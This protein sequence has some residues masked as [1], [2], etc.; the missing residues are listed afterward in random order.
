MSNEQ[1]NNPDENP[2]TNQ[3]SIHDLNDID[4]Q[5]EYTRFIQRRA[6]I[7]PMES[8]HRINVLLVG[9]GGREHAYYSALKQSNKLG[10]VFCYTGQ[11]S[12]TDGMG[13]KNPGILATYINS[14][15]ELDNI[16]STIAFALVGP[17]KFL[18]DG[19]VDD[20][21]NI[22]IP[23]IG[24][25]KNL[26]QIETSKLFARKI[27]DKLRI[28]DT[29]KTD[30]DYKNNDFSGIFNPYYVVID[31][32]L[33]INSITLKIWE[34]LD[35]FGCR[36]LVVK[37]DG[38]ASGKGV[39]TSFSYNEELIEYVF[40][41]FKTRKCQRV[42][43]EEKLAGQ[44]FTLMS[45]CDG[46]KL[47]HTPVVFDYKVD[48]PF[49]PI[50]TGG[51]GSVLTN[52]LHFG[53]TEA[54]ISLAK[55]INQ[56]VID[57]M[58][59]NTAVNNERYIGILYGSFIKT[60]K[61]EIK[62]IEYNARGGDSEIIN[63]LD[64]METQF[65]DVCQSMVNGDICDIKFKIDEYLTNT[66]NNTYIQSKDYINIVKY[67]V[68]IGYPNTVSDLITM[69]PINISH[70]NKLNEGGND[71]IGF[72]SY[73]NGGILFSGLNYNKNGYNN[74]ITCD[75]C[76]LTG[77]R[78]IAII[79]RGHNISKC[80]SVI[81]QLYNYILNNTTGLLTND[82]L[83]LLKTS[84]NVGISSSLRTN[85]LGYTNYK[86]N[87]LTDNINY[88]ND[89]DNAMTY[90]SAGVDD[91]KV[92]DILRN[93][94]PN[95]KET[96]NTLVKGGTPGMGGGGYYGEYDNLLT[97]ID[98]VGTKSIFALEYSTDI[99]KCMKRLANDL[100]YSVYNDILVGGCLEP[101]FFM[102]YF[103]GSCKN[104]ELLEP[105]L[106]ELS[107]VCKKHKC[108]LIGGET[109][110]MEDMYGP[111]INIIGMV[112]GKRS[113]DIN[114]VEM[115]EGDYIYGLPS[116][117]PHANGY[118]LIRKVIDKVRR[119]EGIM[120]NLEKQ[121]IPQHI[122]NELLAPTK[123]YSSIIP[124]FDK[125]SG[126]AHI[127]G[128][129][130]KNIE[131][132]LTNDVN[133][134]IECGMWDIPECF[135]WLEYMGDIPSNEMYRVFN[136]GIGYIVITPEIIHIDNAILIGKLE[137]GNGNVTIKNILPQL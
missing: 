113:N 61:N 40:N 87:D 26:A 1:T 37:F 33:S 75:Y 83:P 136:M 76:Y 90:S 41:I 50:N 68:P 22:G 77:S 13:V 112:V 122:I 96:H 18:E 109:A 45:L 53:I 5:T 107:A 23:T 118:T 25:T 110:T 54:D 11:Q 91:D 31:Q 104:M 15:S 117:G 129:G 94:I 126:M 49:N 4:I 17:E 30:F 36:N 43:I 58:H 78:A 116:N 14:L 128:G 10:K 39:K 88:N 133:A 137:K 95:I 120:F 99:N 125:I 79:G 85:N 69:I 121:T 86:I 123:D 81:N 131:R 119:K 8:N 38:L 64:N 67:Y 115:K 98:G 114:W 7:Y 60:T 32:N 124:Q 66:H 52:P 59:K 80:I 105:F 130:F 132:I 82:K 19:I 74:E 134:I 6:G 21:K 35:K 89:N 108:A 27:L 24:P 135:E 63:V 62:V 65:M 46:N 20:L 101:M 2:N 28:L 93:C 106:K 72:D 84:Q 71:R 70:F 55:R 12:G 47:I 97:S 102:D 127:T 92:G 51:Y 3:I 48:D 29:L 57:D 44:E 100:Y 34:I 56:Y 111:N 73:L 42:L 16:S 9:C 103:G